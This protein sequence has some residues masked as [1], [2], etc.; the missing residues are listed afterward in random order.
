M[1]EIEVPIAEWMMDQTIGCSG[2]GE[3]APF[4]LREF[5]AGPVEP[6]WQLRLLGTETVETGPGPA[7]AWRWDLYCPD[8]ANESS[9]R[10]R[11][12]HLRL[13]RPDRLQ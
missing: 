7:R 11:A 12:P 3:V 1:L 5:E 4:S 13:K 10:P 8:C 2:C 9:P 6:G